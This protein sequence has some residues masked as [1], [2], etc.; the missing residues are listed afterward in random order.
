MA[1]ADTARRFVTALTTLQGAQTL[2]G[3]SWLQ[4]ARAD[5]IARFGAGGLPTPRREA[6]KYTSLAPLLGTTFSAP[7]A[8]SAD[9]PLARDLRGLVQAYHPA[10][11][12]PTVLTFVNGHH[13][14]DHS[15]IGRLP[16][17]VVVGALRSAA[18]THAAALR[19]HLGAIAT[20]GDDSHAFVALNTGFLDDGA[21]VLVPD[22]VVVPYPIN[23][24]HVTT[25]PTTPTAIHPRTL[26]VLGRGSQAR[27]VERFAS[28]GQ[29]AYLCNAVTEADVG[30]GAVLQHT[31]LQNDSERA[32]HLSTLAIRQRRDSSVT[33]HLTSIG[34][35]L[36]RNE[37]TVMLNEPGA[38]VRLD[39]LYLARGTQHVDNQLSVEHVAGSCTSDQLYKGVLDGK[40]SAVFNGRVHVRKDAQRTDAHQ[41]NRN[42]LLST[43]ASIN[44]KP[45]LE[46]FANDV[47]CSHGATI[48]QLDIDALFYLR[49]R[50]VPLEEA[51]AILTLAFAS[52]V[53]E[54]ETDGHYRTFAELLL[55]TWLAQATA[56]G[57]L[58]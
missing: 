40:A 49:A 22:G 27:V 42:L 52:D 35:A 15:H 6:W 23:V 18:V 24:L 45:Q 54:R 53:L 51:R 25:R 56:P 20:F 39:G 47:K 32:Y 30:P 4:Q 48:G 29:G 50:G 38:S 55:T 19:P 10:T 43:Q 31:K 58:A 2:P 57:V 34:A 3:P 16:D 26:V 28:L 37:T 7:Q 33:C 44:T 5:G 36:A 21:V 8:P 11:D 41:A 1:G 9:R 17:K 12:D 46:I 14:A 13:Q